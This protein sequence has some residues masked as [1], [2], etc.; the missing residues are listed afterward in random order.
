MKDW[1]SDYPG[2]CREK[3]FMLIGVLLAVVLWFGMAA[4]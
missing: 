4:I 2:S 1:K 3:K